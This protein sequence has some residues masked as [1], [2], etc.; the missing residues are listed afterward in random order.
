M[1]NEDLIPDYSNELDEDIYAEL[2]QN[3]KIK[4]LKVAHLNINGL[5]HKLSEVQVQVYFTTNYRSQQFTLNYQIQFRTHFQIAVL[6]Y[7]PNIN[8]KNEILISG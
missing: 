1:N 5:F 2:K 3:L 4:G 7:D 6:R 8:M